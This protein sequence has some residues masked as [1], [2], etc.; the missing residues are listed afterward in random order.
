M[1]IDARRDM[2]SFLRGG[3]PWTTKLRLVAIALP[4]AAFCVVVGA[5]RGA[6]SYVGEIVHELVEAWRICDDEAVRRLAD[7]TRKDQP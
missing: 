5:V 2:K 7:S 4:A 6:A 3:P 1:S